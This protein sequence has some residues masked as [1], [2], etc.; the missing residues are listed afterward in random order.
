MVPDQHMRLVPDQQQ[1]Q[2]QASELGHLEQLAQHT[3][4]EEYPFRVNPVCVQQQQHN[5][6]HQWHKQQWHKRQDDKRTLQQHTNLQ[7]KH[8]HEIV[9]CGLH[10]PLAQNS[11]GGDLFVTPLFPATAV[12]EVS[13][14]QMGGGGREVPSGYWG[15]GE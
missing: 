11:A 13:I 8:R 7:H 14:H 10:A 2:Q 4:E 5:Q 12:T 15:S 6:L 9:S 3:S 1:Q